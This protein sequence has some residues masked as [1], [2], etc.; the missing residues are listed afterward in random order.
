MP[1]YT[2]HGHATSGATA[3]RPSNCEIGFQFF[4]TTTNQL[5]TYNGTSWLLS[6]GSP[7]GTVATV[8]ATGSTQAN[9]IA[10]SALGYGFTLVSAAD[11]TKVVA[12]PA[13]VAG[14]VVTI[15]NNA[16]N[17]LKVYPQLADAINAG[18]ANAVYNM[19]N[20]S[21]ATFYAYDATTWYTVPLVAS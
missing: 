18:A 20:L 1:A 4:N 14:A 21:A 7:A 17:V 12:L 15:K 10:N 11:G 16:D 6:N 13:A 2:E 9:A 3:A 5:E 8:A 19:T